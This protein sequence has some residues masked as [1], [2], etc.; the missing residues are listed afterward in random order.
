M[1]F[2]GEK[3]EKGY[4]NVSTLINPGETFYNLADDHQSQGNDGEYRN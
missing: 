1:Q 4:A 3:G 2:P